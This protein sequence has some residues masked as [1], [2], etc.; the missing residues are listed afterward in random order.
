MIPGLLE[1]GDTPEIGG[2][3]APRP[4]IWEIGTR[5]SLVVKGWDEKAIERLQRAY[6]AAG[7]PEN[8]EFHRFGGGHEWS[9]ATTRTMLAKH[10]KST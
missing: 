10:L 9:G 7:K 6:A 3:I 5:D 4:C 2:L 8:L 1:F